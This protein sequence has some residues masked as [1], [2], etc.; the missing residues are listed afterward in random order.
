MR[1]DNSRVQRED[2]TDGMMIRE[3]RIIAGKRCFVFAD[4]VP[5]VMLVEPMDERDLEFLDREIEV[6]T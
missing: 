5:E 3:E 4:E 1:Y 6:L 2:Q